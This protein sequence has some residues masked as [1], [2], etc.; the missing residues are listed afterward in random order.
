MFHAVNLLVKI[1]E[2]T[3][4][5]GDKR[6]DENFELLAKKVVTKILNHWKQIL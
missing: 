2:F 6:R 4:N 5:G 1:M 3:L